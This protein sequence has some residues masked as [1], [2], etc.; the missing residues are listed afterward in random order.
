MFIAEFG[1][2]GVRSFPLFDE[3]D[4][5]GNGIILNTYFK[6]AIVENQRLME[7]LEQAYQR[8]NALTGTLA[9][10]RHRI[11]DVMNVIP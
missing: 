2:D 1:K 5:H 6:S 3:I 11:Q 10:L 7:E 4:E 8:I 9:I